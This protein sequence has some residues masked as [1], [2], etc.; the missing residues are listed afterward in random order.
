M[1]TMGQNLGFQPLVI[2][3]CKGEGPNIYRWYLVGI[4]GHRASGKM[5][6]KKVIFEGCFSNFEAIFDFF[7]EISKTKKL[8]T[9]TFYG[10]NFRSLA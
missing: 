9:I 7:F 1:C 6:P 3:H 10:K 4:G 2:Y 5:R 8:G